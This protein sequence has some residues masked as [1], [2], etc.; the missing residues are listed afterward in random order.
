MKLPRLH[1]NSALIWR[2]AIQI[3][4]LS[5]PCIGLSTSLYAQKMSG[6][7]Q[8]EF[9]GL[10]YERFSFWA[11]DS[12]SYDANDYD[13]RSRVVGIGTYSLK[14]KILQLVFGQMTDTAGVQVARADTS[15][16]DGWVQVRVRC[17]DEQGEP[18]PF[19]TIRRKGTY[20][21]SQI[22]IDGKAV[23]RFR[24]RATDTLVF[25][26]LGYQQ[27]HIPIPGP[28]I[29]DVTISSDSHGYSA[30]TKGEI[31]KYKIARSTKKLLVLQQLHEGQL[32]PERMLKRISEQ[33]VKL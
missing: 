23:M 20:E 7:Y 29:Y 2:R 25:S 3:L 33:P 4:L 31:Y 32:Q 17:V 5:F 28:G 26:S 9:Q 16:S 19:A 21:G 10:Y 22:D 24:T 8:L 27:K 12:F 11:R 6:T 13:L 14:N 30:R 18:I 1:S 15:A